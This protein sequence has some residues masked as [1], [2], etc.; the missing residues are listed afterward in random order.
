MVGVSSPMYQESLRKGARFSSGLLAG[1]IVAA[2]SISVVL[3]TVQAGIQLMPLDSRRLVFVIVAV[4]FAIRDLVNRTPFLWRQVPQRL[5]LQGMDV[6][7]GC[8]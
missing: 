4:A 3:V 2:V 6:N 8:Q 7:I 5:Y 1:Y